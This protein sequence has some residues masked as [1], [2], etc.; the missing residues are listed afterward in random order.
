[1]CALAA[2]MDGG[3]TR[4]DVFGAAEPS[5]SFD[6]GTF[7]WSL[8]RMDGSAIMNTDEPIVVRA[9]AEHG[10]ARYGMQA[11]FPP[12]GVPYDVLD[13]GMYVAGELRFS[14]ASNF[15]SDKV[16]GTI[17]EA[18]ATSAAINAPVESVGEIN[19][20]LYA[21]TTSPGVDA[22]QMPDPTLINY[23]VA[24]GE[25]IN[26]G[27][28]P[29][30]LGTPALKQALLSPTSNPYGSTN[31]FGIYIIDCAGGN[32]IVEEIRIVGTLVLLNSTGTTIIGRNTLIEPAYSWMPSLLVQGNT[33][34]MGT[35]AGPSEVT[36]GINLNPAHT[37]SGMEWD[38]A[39]DDTYE[40]AI[41]G[42]SYVTGNAYFALPRQNIRGTMIIG[43]D[44]RVY[45]GVTVNIEYDANVATLP[46]YG[47]FEDNGGLAIDP[48]TVTWG[49]PF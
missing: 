24:L 42:V 5:I 35:N 8:R 28:L 29:T 47:F 30:T 19:G 44:A 12:S 3:G 34:Y 4:S 2:H 13:T 39:A 41:K 20:S 22:R 1:M 17:T 48:S 27:S 32:L 26:V 37:P 11:I 38:A 14:T 33:S 15:T 40:G 25:R 6:G 49:V 21:G 9:K 31:E 43:G 16:V 10:P 36:L 46:P 23:Y 18:F 7:G 45:G